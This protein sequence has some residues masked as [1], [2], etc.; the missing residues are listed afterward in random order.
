MGIKWEDVKVGV[1]AITG[2]VFI[3]KVKNNL[4]TDRSAD[5]SLEVVRAV[6]EKIIHS[7]EDTIT[8]CSGDKEYE[9]KLTIKETQEER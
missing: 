3:G 1:G 2:E 7:E 9:L 6:V 5:K 4:W 8:L